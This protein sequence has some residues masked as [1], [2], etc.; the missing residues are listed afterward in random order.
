M[1]LNGTILGGGNKKLFISSPG[2]HSTRKSTFPSDTQCVS[3]SV[4]ESHSKGKKGRAG[5]LVL[6]AVPA[7]AGHLI[8]VSPHVWGGKG[9]LA[10][11]APL[12]GLRC[13]IDAFPG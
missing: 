1:W 4:S 7:V 8:T 12:W 5:C 13:A 10:P 9:F 11:A 6:G 2:P 3:G